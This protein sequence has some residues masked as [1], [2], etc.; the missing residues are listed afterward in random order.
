M[1]LIVHV[2][3][4]HLLFGLSAQFGVWSAA[5]ITS[6]NESASETT[7]GTKAS[8]MNSV[9]L[10]LPSLSASPK[11]LSQSTYF[12]VKSGENIA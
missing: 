4:S 5:M 6:Q 9:I 11:A 12:I 2:F 3:H 1:I 8:Q 7:A 10:K